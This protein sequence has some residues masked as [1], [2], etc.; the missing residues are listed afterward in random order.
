MDSVLRFAPV[1]AR[2]LLGLMF[3][4]F[5]A[6][7]FLQFIPLPPPPPAALAFLGGLGA[8]GYVFPLLSATELVAGLMLLSNRFVPLA[9]VLL[10]PVVVN[11]MAYHLVLAPPDVPSILATVGELYLA[12]VYRASFRGV[13]ATRVVPS[14]TK[15]NAPASGVG[16]TA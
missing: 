10:A 4:V 9:L 7:G 13:L 8:S 2:L 15:A 16:V 1:L 11:I 12:W 5:G 6:N 14:A 3:A